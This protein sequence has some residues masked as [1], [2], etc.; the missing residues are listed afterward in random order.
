M[1]KIRL[2]NIALCTTVRALLEGL[3]KI[4]PEWYNT[5]VGPAYRNFAGN[6]YNTGGAK[7]DRPRD[8]RGTA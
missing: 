5:G 7:H 3:D 8:T 6:I 1:P 2:P 4:S